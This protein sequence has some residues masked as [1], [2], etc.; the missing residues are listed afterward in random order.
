VN[1]YIKNWYCFLYAYVIIVLVLLYING[2][3]GIDMI[4]T[5]IKLIAKQVAYAIVGVATVLAYFPSVVNAAQLTTRKVQIGNSAA[6]TTT[7][8]FTFTTITSTVVQGVKFQACTTPSG[9]C[10][11][12]T[13]FSATGSTLTSTTGSLGTTGWTVDNSTATQLAIH[14]TTSTSTPGSTTVNFTNV[15]NPTGAPAVFYMWITTYSSYS[16]P[17]YTGP[18]D[19]GTVAT[20][21][22]GN[23]TVAANVDE[24]LSFTV[25]NT[26]VTMTP[27][28]TSTTTGTGTSTL[29]IST[30]GTG[31][32]IGY[33]GTTLTS[34]ANSIAALATKTAAAAG[35]AQFGINLMVNTAPAVGAVNTGSGTI[36]T[37]YATANSFTFIAGTSNTPVATGTRAV[38][39]YTVSYIANIPAT[40]APGAYTA[41]ANYVATATF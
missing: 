40:Q 26:A 15:T 22:A 23:V 38:D 17:N 31:Y 10:T 20:A 29:A 11:A 30:N 41:T 24:T 13:G 1:K 36:A 12:P 33:S 6:L 3:K 34:G 8:S 14:N 25:G 7:Y 16:S 32:S 35:G 37:D 18:I 19:L 21:T 27:S 39:T 5:N 28:L 2:E 9:T 4:K